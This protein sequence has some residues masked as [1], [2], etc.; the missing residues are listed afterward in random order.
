MR[1]LPLA[2]LGHM[3][4]VAQIG[5]KEVLFHSDYDLIGRGDSCVSCMQLVEQHQPCLFVVDWC[6]TDGPTFQLIEALSR[7]RRW[8]KILCWTAAAQSWLMHR[9]IESGAHGVLPQTASSHD[10]HEALAQ[11]EENS[12]PFMPP[13]LRMEV[14]NLGR[15]RPSCLHNPIKLLSDRQL[16]VFYLIGCGLS[17]KGIAC[18]LGVS[19]KTVDTHRAALK[20]M[21]NYDSADALRQAAYEWLFRI[22]V[23]PHLGELGNLSAPP[24]QPECLKLLA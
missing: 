11:M 23:E 8:L 15:G 3:N 12:R 2:V 21:L 18:K 24:A 17:T 6:L 14:A 9:A 22:N 16:Q 5:M 13:L 7:T 4:P 20:G 1:S 10:V 19:A